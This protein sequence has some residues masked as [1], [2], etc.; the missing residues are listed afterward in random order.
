[1]KD[2]RW[3]RLIQIDTLSPNEEL[4]E[5]DGSVSVHHR[6]VQSVYVYVESGVER[7]V[8]SRNIILYIWLVELTN[9]TKDFPSSEF[10]IFV[11]SWQIFIA[12]IPEVLELSSVPSQHLPA[13]S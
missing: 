9:T 12:F 7:G 10:T 13:Q 3:L 2:E 11:I 6:N 4:L 1:M 8:S 5:K